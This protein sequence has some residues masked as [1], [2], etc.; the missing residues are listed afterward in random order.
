MWF[1]FI[2]DKCKL[3]IGN[4]PPNCL[5]EYLELFFENRRQVGDSVQVEVVAV[6][7]IPEKNEAVIEFK[8]E[9]RKYKT[10]QIKIVS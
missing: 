9:L 4:L 2:L 8:E 10:S 1:G 3:Q 7:M 5:D 6:D